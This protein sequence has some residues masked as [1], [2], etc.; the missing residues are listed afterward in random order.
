LNPLNVWSLSKA[1][2]SIEDIEVELSEW[3]EVSKWFKLTIK[4]KS[5]ASKVDLMQAL[6]KE[7]KP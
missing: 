4:I 7:T 6:R 2:E 1:L 3:G 5:L